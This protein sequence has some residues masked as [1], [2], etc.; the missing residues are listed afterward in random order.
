MIFLV[1]ISPLPTN[2]SEAAWNAAAEGTR[3]STQLSY[4]TLPPIYGDLADCI[5]EEVSGLLPEGMFSEN[6]DEAMAAVSEASSFGYLFSMVLNALGLRLGDALT[7]LCTL[8][9]LLLM[10]AIM[11]SLRDTIGG[12]GGELFGFCLRLVMYAAIVGQAAGMIALVSGYFDQLST[13]TTAMIPVMG[14]LYALG[15]N[16]GQAALN[17]ELLMIFLNVIQYIATTVTPPFCGIC[18]AFSLLDAFECR[19]K[20]APLG[21]L[22]KKWYTGAL[23]FIMFLLGTVLTLQSVLTS[24]ADTL[25]MRGVKYAVSSWI[26]VVGGTVAGTLGTV[27]TVMG[28]LRGICG[29]AGVVLVLLLL[30]PTLLQVMLFRWMFQLSSSIAGMLGCDGE[31]RLMGEMAGLYGYIAAAVTLCSLLFVLALGLLIASAPALG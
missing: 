6:P 8:V 14:T 9:G 13:L 26:P 15:G 17:G 22:I 3:E 29:T 10:A 16:I 18:L 21:T 25:A 1:W 23:G 11:R 2:A 5:P 4:D 30:L 31:S 19:L 27:S 7:L 20:L 24:R 28:S 12:K